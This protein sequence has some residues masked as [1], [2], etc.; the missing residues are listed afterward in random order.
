MNARAYLAELLGTFLFLLIGYLSVA[1]ASTAGDSTLLVVPFSFGLGLLAAIV[2]FGHVSGGHFNPAVTM[3]A[4]MER[5]LP[6]ADGLGYMLAQVIG[7]LGAAAVVYATISQE[8][9]TA[10]ITAPGAGVT[11]ISALILEIILTAVFIT[12]ILSATTGGGRL[13]P[14]VIPLALVAIHFAIAPLTG[15]SVNPARS[16]GSALVG[17]SLDGLWIYILGPAVGGI[18]GALIYRFAAG[19]PPDAAPADPTI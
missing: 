19:M 4:L 17:G 18:A 2:A 7:A 12:V 6:P 11:E 5:R 8:A 15:A 1:A 9:V 14:V 16:L 3:A 13:A 10:G